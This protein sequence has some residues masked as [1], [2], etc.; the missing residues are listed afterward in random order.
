M[1][2]EA[3]WANREKD[4]NG[5]PL[6]E[7][8]DLDACPSCGA[9]NVFVAFSVPEIRDARKHV[10]CRICKMQGPERCNVA[11]AVEYWN[12]LPRR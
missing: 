11:E 3:T 12:N 6:K 7:G 5:L 4:R 1:T 9:R 2:I 10:E 8:H